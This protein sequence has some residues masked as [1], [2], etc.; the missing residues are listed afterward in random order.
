MALTFFTSDTHFGHFNIIKY[1][2]R[3]FKT[4]FEM[5]QKIINRWNER[6]KPED[7]V[8]FLGDFCFKT[9]PGGNQG[10]GVAVHPNVYLAQLN[11]NKQF[12]AGNHDSHNALN[13]KTQF[14]VCEFGGI[15][16]KLVH[17]PEHADSQYPLNICGHVHNAWQTKALGNKSLII[18]CGL[19]LNDYYPYSLD[20]IMGIY[21]KW[22]NKN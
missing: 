6:I 13:V 17:K 3:P 18:N 8:Y 21:S 19:E 22:K 4:L 1:C 9:S 11:G 16:V 5:N 7:T 2:D 15:R 20:E 12:I 10:E 14:M